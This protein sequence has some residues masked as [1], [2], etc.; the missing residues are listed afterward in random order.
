MIYLW[1]RKSCTDYIENILVIRFSDNNID[2]E[3][4][5]LIGVLEHGEHKLRN[6]INEGDLFM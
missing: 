2:K 3:A 6:Y 1:W 5:I 4:I